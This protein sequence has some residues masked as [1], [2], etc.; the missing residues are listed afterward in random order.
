MTLE[1]EV[2]GQRS[3]PDEIAESFREA[4]RNG[5]YDDATSL[6]AIWLERIMMTFN[7]TYRR[8][9]EA[10]VIF[11]RDKG[12]TGVARGILNMIEY[13]ILEWLPLGWVDDRDLTSE[14]GFLTGEGLATPE[15]EREQIERE[16]EERR[17]SLGASHYLSVASSDHIHSHTLREE[18][19][20]KF[21]FAMWARVLQLDIQGRLMVGPCFPYL[22][23]QDQIANLFRAPEP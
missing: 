8:A 20:D 1:L 21:H 14:H 3:G 17:Q 12:E 11:L 18:I 4:M 16:R 10:F 15:R 22:P 2:Q 13:Y 6:L 5:E 9:L 7:V 19:E 23:T